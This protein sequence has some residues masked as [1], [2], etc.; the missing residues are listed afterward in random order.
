MT[1]FTLL[2]KGKTGSHVIE[3]AKAKRINLIKAL[4]SKDE[5]N[6][7]E[8]NKGNGL[9]IFT[10]AQAVFDHF[11]TLLKIECP[12]IIGAT[13]FEW[14]QE[15]MTQIK[16]NHRKWIHG[17]NFSLGM[18]IIRHLFTSIQTSMNLIQDHELSIHEIH[19]TKKLDAPS[20]TALRWQHWLGI[21]NMEIT[22]DRT[23][24][25]I[26]IHEFT[27]KNK[28]EKIQ[29]RHESLDRKLFA[30]GA[31]WALE[32]QDLLDHFDSGIIPFEDMVDHAINK[33]RTS[34]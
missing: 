19:H 22:H 15:Q 25:V 4:G 7:T 18:N 32:N 21:E 24:D 33:K 12:L 16:T 30:Q 5:I 28:Q 34:L 31:L 20:G 11:Q 27:I 3:L 1:S 9:I 14:S 13:G 10:P 2:G 26:G 29:I 17:H 8:I 6:P 23:G